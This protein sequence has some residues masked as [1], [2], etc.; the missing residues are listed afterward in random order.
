MTY[1]TAR[2]SLRVSLKRKGRD[3]DLPV[4]SVRMIRVVHRLT[5]TGTAED[6]KTTAWPVPVVLH[7]SKNSPIL[8]SDKSGSIVHQP[9]LRIVKFVVFSFVGEIESGLIN[10][11]LAP[12]PCGQFASPLW[13][14]S[15]AFDI[16]LHS[17]LWVG[18]EEMLRI[19]HRTENEMVE[20]ERRTDSQRLG[21]V[22]GEH[23]H[24]RC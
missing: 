20:S 18:H 7:D 21:V 22:T 6:E 12:I 19:L 2:P 1:R 14:W 4:E 17:R 23:P 15:Q 16:D 13:S 3:S 24:V 11:T 8:A 5:G 9:N 10:R